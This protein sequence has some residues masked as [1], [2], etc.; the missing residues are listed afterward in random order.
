MR[1]SPG[2]GRPRKRYLE[3]ALHAA[4][5]MEPRPP[6]FYGLGELAGGLKRAY[7]ELG[8]VWPSTLM[9]ALERPSRARTPDELP[10]PAAMERLPGFPLR[11]SLPLPPGDPLHRVS[12]F[13]D[14]GYFARVEGLPV[15]L[16]Q[17][18]GD[19]NSRFRTEE[20][21][22]LAG[23][24]AFDDEGLGALEGRPLAG[25]HPA[26]PTPRPCQSHRRP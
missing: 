16:M 1:N 3:L 4:D 11:V 8:K 21:M 15:I 18:V 10:P 19:T 22:K 24:I 25:L 13:P 7:P 23:V 12:H 5:Y 14:W 2:P 26:L 9:R 20:A 6:S 17:L